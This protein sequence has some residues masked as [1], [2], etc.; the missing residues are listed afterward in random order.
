M[1]V[2]K[3]GVNFINITDRENTRIFHVKSDNEEIILCNN[4]NDIIKKLDESSLFN[5]QKEEQILTNGS[6]YIFESDDLLN[7]HFHNIKLKR[8]SSYIDSPDLIKN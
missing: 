7:I 2:N 6:N 8:D 1:V 4:T 3:M 5:Y